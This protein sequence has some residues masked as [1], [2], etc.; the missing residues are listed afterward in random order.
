MAVTDSE[1]NQP[2]RNQLLS[3][4]TN[5]N[6]QLRDCVRDLAGQVENLRTRRIGLPHECF[7]GVSTSP[8]RGL[9]REEAE[10]GNPRRHGYRNLEVFPPGPHDS[11]PLNGYGRCGCGGDYDF[12]YGGDYDCDYG[13][14]HPTASL[15]P[16]PPGRARRPS[17]TPRSSPTAAPRFPPLEP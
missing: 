10:A 1:L 11:P 14:V 8:L 12:G 2:G 3:D 15:P 9:V 4:L 16:G 5:E 13:G 17:P 7:P 6:D